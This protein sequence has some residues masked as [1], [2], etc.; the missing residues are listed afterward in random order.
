MTLAGSIVADEQFCNITGFDFDDCLSNFAIS[1]P[2][3]VIMLDK[4]GKT[5]KA[6]TYNAANGQNKNELV[7]I[8]NFKKDC[9]YVLNTCDNTLKMFS[10]RKKRVKWKRKL[11]NAAAAKK[12]CL[13][14]DKL[15]ITCGSDIAIISATSGDQIGKHE[16]NCLLEDCLGLCVIDNVLVFSSGSDNFETSTKLAYTCM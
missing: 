14:N 7:T 10:F 6:K 8:F 1:T 9:L 16:T 12:M 3:K 13:Y 4:S 2:E 5:V 11:E 15:C